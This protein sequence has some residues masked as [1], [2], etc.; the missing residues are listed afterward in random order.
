[1]QIFAILTIQTP[2]IFRTRLLGNSKKRP[3]FMDINAIKIICN[4]AKS[5]FEILCNGV[6]QNLNKWC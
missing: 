4:F 5:F 6:R 1:M 2:F 3:I